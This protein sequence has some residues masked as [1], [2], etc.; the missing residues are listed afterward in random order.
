[1]LFPHGSTPSLIAK[2][3]AASALYGIIETV[4]DWYRIFL[5]EALMR[6]DDRGLRDVTELL[7]GVTSL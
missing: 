7:A 6:F 1:M 5:P 4:V 2:P 3:T